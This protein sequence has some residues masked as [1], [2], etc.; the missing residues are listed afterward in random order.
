[1]LGAYIFI[2]VT[3]WALH[4]YVVLFSLIS[5][6]FKVYFGLYGY[7][8]SSFLL[9]FSCTEILFPFPHFQSLCVPRSEMGLSYFFPYLL[10][11]VRLFATLWTVAHQAPLSMG[12]SRQEYGS[13]LSFPSPGDLPNPGIKPTSVPPALASRFFYHW[14]TWEVPRLNAM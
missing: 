9:I 2:M 6:W 10:S 1:M 14:A 7:C 11:R 4:H 8:F 12:F 3:S 5:L 13:G